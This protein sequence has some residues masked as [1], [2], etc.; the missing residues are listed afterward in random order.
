MFEVRTVQHDGR[1]V[2]GKTAGIV[3]TV[4]AAAHALSNETTKEKRLT[5]NLALMKRK[6]V[7]RTPRSSMGRLVRLLCG[8]RGES[9]M[10]L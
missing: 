6:R 1:I 8:R 9:V 7:E 4:A 5:R 2:D 3:M 10:R